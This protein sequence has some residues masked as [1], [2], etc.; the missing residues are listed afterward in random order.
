MSTTR[1][2]LTLPPLDL[3]QAVA[4]RG[5]ALHAG[6]IST[7]AL[8]IDGT[9][10]VPM[11]DPISSETTFQITEHTTAHPDV[12]HGRIYFVAVVSPGRSPY[13]F[14]LAHTPKDAENLA[15]MFMACPPPGKRYGYITVKPDGTLWPTQWASKNARERYFAST[16]TESESTP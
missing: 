6:N 10:W 16:L 15:R 3:V 14:G 11:V 12:P 7:Q 1:T 2:F 13:T 8:G 9:V 4:L 5:K